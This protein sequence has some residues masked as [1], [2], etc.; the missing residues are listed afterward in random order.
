PTLKELLALYLERKTL[1][2]ATILTYQR[3]INGCLADW[4][5]KPITMIDEE[6]VQTRHRELSKLNHMGTMG[7]DQANA[8]MHVLSRLLNYAADNLQSPDGQPIIFLNPVQKLNQN[9]L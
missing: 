7:H 5:D 8:S 6:M 3:V 4:L 9:K 2:Q 1:R